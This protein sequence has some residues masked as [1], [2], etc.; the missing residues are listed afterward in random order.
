MWRLKSYLK[1]YW[2][3]SLLAPLF[4]VLE[5]WMDLLQPMLMASIIN[6]GIVNRDLTHIQHTGL[7][8]I[9]VA[10]IGVIGGIGCS[11]FSSIASQNFG[12][13]LRNNLFEKVQ[14][15]SF[16]N[17]DQLETGSLITRLTNDVMQMQT[18]VQMIMRAFIRSPLLFVGSFIMA[19][20]ISPRLTLILAVATPLLFIVLVILI[21]KSFPL[22][23]KV[24]SKLDGV[25]SVLQENLSGI[26]V[27]KAFVRANYEG[28][29]FG[30]ANEEYTGVAI[31]AARLMAINMPMMT[32]I[33]NVSVVAVLW[34]GGGLTQGGSLST[35]DLIAFINYVTQLL[36][37][38]LMIS[39][40]L[41]FV[42]RAKVSA[43][44]I[45]E[46]LDTLTEITDP[47]QG[48]SNK[49]EALITNGY[50]QF[51]NVSFAYDR[52]QAELVL[53]NISFHA[54]SGQTLAIL[55]AT[56]SGKS[57]LISLI[58]RLYDTTS[59]SIL[60]D[61]I[62]IKD[63]SLDY[64]RSHIGMVMQ[65]SIL[66]TGTIRDNISYGK[67]DAN[68]EE[69]EAAAI[70]AEAHDFIQQMPDG[71]DTILGQ[72]GVN[73]SGGQK[74]RISIARALLL[75]PVI[76]ILDDSTSAVDLGTESRIQK[77]LRELMNNTTNI[78]IAQRISSVIDAD[79]IIILDDNGTIAGEG[80]HD[81]LLQNS[82][83]YQDIYRSQWKEEDTHVPVN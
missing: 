34:Y 42:S 17:L 56:G 28:K 51:K 5:V 75:R 57:S 2:V 29:R 36:F 15:F 66:F 45:N 52:A 58:P 55:G 65:Q 16:R 6:D 33:L 69:I 10:L 53:H 64:L 73:L 79:H 72:Q 44:R 38:M 74:Q 50:I 39:S 62:N 76:L 63:I 24:Q 67:S 21:R 80:T 11:I 40:L 7:I 32:L 49:K 3:S 18:F 46:V 61:G 31:K 25:N 14:T 26:R 35:G 22:F 37:S 83:I 20:S 8:M 27:V 82:S 9:G 43:A 68:Q 13:D 1:P 47:I 77:S 48:D 71:Y 59:G 54:E 41:P 70:A 60:I 23:T 81:E 12:R 78:I 4:M 19:F 30:T